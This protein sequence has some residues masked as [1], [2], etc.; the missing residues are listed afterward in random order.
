[1]REDL[2]L[3]TPSLAVRDRSSARRARATCLMPRMATRNERSSNWS[4]KGT[5]LLDSP[6]RLG[7]ITH[8][9]AVAGTDGRA[10]VDGPKRAPGPQGPGQ[11]GGIRISRARW[12]NLRLGKSCFSR[13]EGTAEPDLEPGLYWTR[14][15][16]IRY[17]HTSTFSVGYPK[18]G[19]AKRHYD[20]SG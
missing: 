1:M 10:Q 19:I 20:F 13:A 7:A 18:K 8:G 6:R 3:T 16:W 17:S 4:R 15:R 11:T 2:H 5:S 12:R 14:E 9:V